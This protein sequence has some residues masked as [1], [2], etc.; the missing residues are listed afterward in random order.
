VF[1]PRSSVA[2]AYEELWAEA[3]ARTPVA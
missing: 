3:Q 1:A 2:R